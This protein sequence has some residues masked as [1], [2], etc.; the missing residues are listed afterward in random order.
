MFGTF[1]S[2]LPSLPLLC[3]LFF[4]VLLSISI[5]SNSTFVFVF[6]RFLYVL[7]MLKNFNLVETTVTIATVCCCFTWFLYHVGYQ[8]VH[9]QQLLESNLYCQGW[10]RLRNKM[11]WVELRWD[12]MHWVY[13]QMRRMKRKQVLGKIM[14][15]CT[16]C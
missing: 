4:H 11:R 12:E 16:F 9:Q 15:K 10:I 1:T 13:N 6:I 2:F 8:Y 5:Y 3:L 7:F 14:G